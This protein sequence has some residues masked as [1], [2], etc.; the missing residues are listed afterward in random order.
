M[1]LICG[2]FVV[3]KRPAE[4]KHAPQAHAYCKAEQFY[5][6]DCVFIQPGLLLPLWPLTFSFPLTLVLLVRPAERRDHSFIAL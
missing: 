2:A 3:G 1:N 5:L 4:S 6:P